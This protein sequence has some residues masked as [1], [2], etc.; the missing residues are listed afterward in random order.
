MFLENNLP[1]TKAHV[2]RWPSVRA[3]SEPSVRLSWVVCGFS[4][5]GRSHSRSRSRSRCWTV[6]VVACDVKCGCPGVESVLYNLQHASRRCKNNT[7]K[8]TKRIERVTGLKECKRK[9]EQQHAKAAP[10]APRA[11]ATITRT[12]TTTRR[13]TT[14]TTTSIAIY[15]LMHLRKFMQ[16]PKNTYSTSPVAR[17]CTPADRQ[18][19]RTGRRADAARTARVSQHKFYSAARSGLWTSC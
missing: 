16:I 10:A 6:A 15:C 14:R 5:R 11:T 3:G 13:A 8:A 18:T 1:D 2:E 4:N 7:K 19:G 12:T 9:Q 17:R